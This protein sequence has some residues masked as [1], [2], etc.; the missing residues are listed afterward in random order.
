MTKI[1][2]SN[3]GTCGSGSKGENEKW[4][5]LESQIDVSRKKSEAINVIYFA[6]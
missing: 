4:M 1:S 6:L 3:L 2:A 5:Q